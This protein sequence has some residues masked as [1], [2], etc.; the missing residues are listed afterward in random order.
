MSEAQDIWGKFLEDI[1]GA[2][3]W[4][5]P[6]PFHQYVEFFREAIQSF[7]CYIYDGAI[8][9]SRSTI[10]GAIFECVTFPPMS[11]QGEFVCDACGAK[12]IGGLKGLNF[13]KLSK[14]ERTGQLWDERQNQVK[15]LLSNRLDDFNSNLSSE[16]YTNF[17]DRWE[18]R[19][20]KIGLKNMALFSGLFNEDELRDIHQGIRKQAAIRLHKDAENKALSKWRDENQGKLEKLARNEI[21]VSDIDWFSAERATNAESQKVLKKTAV[22]FAKLVMSYDKIWGKYKL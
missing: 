20:D 3:G 2:E 14:A 12:V 8:I 10:D 21:A 16:R 22:Y 9:L 17:T 18:D 19:K 15:R 4:P 1:K 5:Y 6:A 11:S 7:Q 13:H